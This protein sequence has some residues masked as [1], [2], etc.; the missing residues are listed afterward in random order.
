LAAVAGVAVLL[1]RLQLMASGS[2]PFEVRHLTDA[3]F[4]TLFFVLTSSVVAFL[5]RKSADV[6]LRR[7]R[8][9]H[10]ELTAQ[11]AEL[12]QTAQQLADAVEL[13]DAMLAGITHDLRTPLTVIKVQVQLLQ[14]RT[15]S[16]DNRL[17]GSLEQIE[18]ATGR[19]ARWIDELLEVTRIGSLGELD[20]APT[21][22]VQ[23]AQDVVGEHQ[24]ASPRHTLRLERQ[25]E[26][27][28]GSWDP[29]RL[30]RVLDNLIGNAIKYSPPGREITVEV[31]AHD[32]WA[33]ASVH[34]EGIGIPPADLPHIFEPF[35]R[36]SNV[37]GQVGGTGIGLASAHRIVV[38]HGGTL[39][40]SSTPGAGTTFVV[41][42]PLAPQ[43]VTRNGGADWGQ[44]GLSARC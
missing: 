17:R 27:I 1:S 18:Q 16:L 43:V 40:A 6:V 26:P 24:A 41:R 20:L 11:N 39:E 9:W 4:Y 35:K 2:V 12:E 30:R 22:L 25:A 5:M 8:A 21:D 44:P 19:M 3:V 23:L 37:V 36:G 42:L 34:D 29:D 15:D 38:G 7:E 14:R 28:I 32:G 10:A 33:T 31:A 13:R